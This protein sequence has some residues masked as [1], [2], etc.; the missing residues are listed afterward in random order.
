MKH[1]LN[2]IIKIVVKRSQVPDM[3]RIEI[4]ESGSGIDQN[5][6]A[7]ISIMLDN[8]FQN[9]RTECSSGMY[10]YILDSELRRS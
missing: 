3:I 5:D 4:I 6:M 1:T 8:P 10:V 9:L 2:D 7:K